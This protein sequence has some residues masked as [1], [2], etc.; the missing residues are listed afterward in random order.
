MHTLN[1]LKI[2]YQNWFGEYWGC[3]YR[4]FWRP[5]FWRHQFPL[6]K[7]MSP[8][9]RSSKDPILAALRIWTTE[10]TITETTSIFRYE[11][12]MSSSWASPP[13][14]KFA[15][16]TKWR[17]MEGIGIIREWLGYSTMCWFISLIAILA[18]TWSFTTEIKKWPSRL[19]WF[20]TVATVHK[21][22]HF[23]TQ[24]YQQNIIVVIT[25]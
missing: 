11:K 3:Q 16:T 8:K 2:A 25:E 5:L 6:G 17:L 4:V 9:K 10:A 23:F 13:W 24:H 22:H 1:S 7:L 14:S 18:N 20:V 19:G 15:D 21:N 12:S